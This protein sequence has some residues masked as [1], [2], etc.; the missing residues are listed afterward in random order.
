MDGTNTEVSYD[1]HIFGT[2]DFKGTLPGLSVRLIKDYE[3]FQKLPKNVFSKS[4]YVITDTRNELTAQGTI[5][6]I[7]T[8]ELEKTEI[9]FNNDKN[10]T[11]V[12]IVYRNSREVS[13]VNGKW[14]IIE[15][16]NQQDFVFTYSVSSSSGYQTSYGTKNTRFKINYDEDHEIKS[17]GLNIIY[18]RENYNYIQQQ[19]E[20]GHNHS[21]ISVISL[22]KEL[23]HC[24]YLIL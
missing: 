11:A 23:R 12:Y 2:V 1:S 16:N 9:T 17:I 7:E 24:I 15:E 10:Q 22:F 6:K 5:N 21:N 18:E 19:P 8:K 3:N 13:R 20:N 4:E 14:T